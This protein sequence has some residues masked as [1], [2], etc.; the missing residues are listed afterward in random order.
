MCSVREEAL[1]VCLTFPYIVLCGS[2]W[3]RLQ[4]TTW[5]GRETRLSFGPQVKAGDTVTV[6]VDALKKK[7]RFYRNQAREG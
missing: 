3:L 6:E 4:M 1:S 5:S 2:C 7:V